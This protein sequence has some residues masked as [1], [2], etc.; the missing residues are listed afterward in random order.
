LEYA[1]QVKGWAVPGE[2][3]VGWRFPKEDEIKKTWSDW[4]KLFE[5]QTDLVASI[6]A[7]FEDATR[8]HQA[9]KDAEKK[10]LEG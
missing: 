1:V 9:Q 7:H 2:K 5:S 6:Q 8:R 4:N 10:E 3:T